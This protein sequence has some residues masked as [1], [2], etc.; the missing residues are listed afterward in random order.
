[1][2]ILVPVQNQ[3]SLWDGST[4]QR[5]AGNSRERLSCSQESSLEVKGQGPETGVFREDSERGWPVLVCNFRSYCG[6]SEEN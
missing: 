1:M 4:G 2:A 5:E 6:I 3:V